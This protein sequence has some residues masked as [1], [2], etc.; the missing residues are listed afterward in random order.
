ME[1]KSTKD[2]TEQKQSISLWSDEEHVPSV[3]GS[4]LAFV[5]PEDIQTERVQRKN[6]YP[7]MTHSR[8]L[9]FKPVSKSVPRRLN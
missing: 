8:N 2:F 1:A 7:L 5:T 9:L 6:P 4:A 3:A